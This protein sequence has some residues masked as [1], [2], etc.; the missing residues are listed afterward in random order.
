M[1]DSTQANQASPFWRFSLAFYREEGVAEACIALQEQSSV[2][3]NLLLYLFW[4]AHSQR[5]FSVTDIEWIEQRIAPWRSATVVPLRAVRRSL[6]QPPDLVD[7]GPAEA[8]RNRIKAV[9]LEAERLQ[10]E[11]MYRLE[12]PAG[13]RAI[14]PTEAATTSLAAYESICPVPFSRTA[15]DTLVSRFAASAYRPD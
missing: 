1:T 14:S 7:A 10:Q 4:Q 3:V 2:D 5:A 6:K 13:Q 9:E 11:S 12:V 8:F 15:L